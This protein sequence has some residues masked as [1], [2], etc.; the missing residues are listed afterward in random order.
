MVPFTGGLA[1]RKFCLFCVVGWHGAA[2]FPSS[3][4]K[5]RRAAPHRTRSCSV[6][7]SVPRMPPRLRQFIVRMA[8]L[9]VLLSPCNIHS[10]FPVPPVEAKPNVSQACRVGFVFAACPSLRSW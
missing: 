6:A 8:L 1:D 3:V 9:G 5:F 2:D 4:E 7:L 10:A